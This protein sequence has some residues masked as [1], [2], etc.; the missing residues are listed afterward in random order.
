MLKTTI[1]QEMDNV[2]VNLEGCKRNLCSKL[3]EKFI[4]FETLY[5]DQFRVEL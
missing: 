4:I 5:I 1:L 3:A 2:G